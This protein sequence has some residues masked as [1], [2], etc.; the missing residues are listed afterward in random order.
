MSKKL[1]DNGYKVFIVTPETTDISLKERCRRINSEYIKNH[2][3]AISISI[4]NNAAGADGKW[5]AEG[6]TGTSLRGFQ[7][8]LS[9]GREYYAP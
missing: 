8:G 6:Q 5:H 1:K 2:K 4:H 3:N 9:V 7:A